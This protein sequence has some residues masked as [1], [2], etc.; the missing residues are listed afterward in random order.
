MNLTLHDNFVAVAEC[1][2]FSTS[3]GKSACDVIQ[4]AE[5]GSHKP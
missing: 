2:F 5:S 3:H 4:G 1:Q